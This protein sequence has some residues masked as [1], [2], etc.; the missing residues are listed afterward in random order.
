MIDLNQIKLAQDYIDRGD[1]KLAYHEL[2]LSMG[3]DD[4]Q[5]SVE[6]IVL[7]TE[8]LAQIEPFLSDVISPHGLEMVSQVVDF[9]IGRD[10]LEAD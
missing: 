4:H 9:T 10:A 3:Y 5:P 2:M 1:H 8:T 7:F 6:A